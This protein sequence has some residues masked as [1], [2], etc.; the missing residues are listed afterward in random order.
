MKKNLLDCFSPVTKEDEERV[1]DN[2]SFAPALYEKPKLEEILFGSPVERPKFLD[3][4]DHIIYTGKTARILFMTQELDKGC[5]WVNKEGSSWVKLNGGVKD[6]EIFV[7][8]KS[9]TKTFMMKKVGLLYVMLYY[10]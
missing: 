7:T 8:Y 5:I 4:V 10:A 6:N 1:Y 9:K 2:C 3:D